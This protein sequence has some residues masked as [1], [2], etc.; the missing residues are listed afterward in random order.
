MAVASTMRSAQLLLVVFAVSADARNSLARTPPMGWMSWE[1]FR[2]DSDCKKDPHMCISEQLY[3]DQTDGLADGGFIAAGYTGIHMDDCWEQRKPP[4][5]PKTGELRPEP[6][7]F[8]R[9]HISSSCLPV[10]L[11]PKPLQTT[12]TKQT[13]YILQYRT[14]IT[15]TNELITKTRLIYTH[16]TNNQ[17]LE[18]SGRLHTRQE[19]HLWTVHSRVPSNLWRVPG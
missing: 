18:S 6:T 10:V 4:R 14:T 17:W 11:I 8:P 5:D 16:S 13:T 2:C 1:L 9:S 12:D 15:Q 7:R 19:W 3:K